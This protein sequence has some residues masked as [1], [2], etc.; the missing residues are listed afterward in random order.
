MP[1]TVRI[2]IDIGGTF[3]DLVLLDEDTGEVHTHKLLSRPDDVSEGVMAGLQ[4]LVSDPRRVSFLV[5]GTTVG[6]NT[7]L[8]RRGGPVALLVTEGFRDVYG[9]ARANRQRMYD[10]F[11]KRP[12]PLI[13]RRH[14]YEVPERVLADGTIDSPLDVEA[15][16]GLAHVLSEREYESVAVVF[17]H[18]YM[19]PHHELEAQRTLANMLPNVPLL[20]SHRVAG[21]YREYERT[22]STVLAAYVAPVIERYLES[23]EIKLSRRNYPGPVYLM[24]SGGGVMTTSVARSEAIHTLMSGPV[25]GAVGCKLLSRQLGQ[26]NLIC[27][28]MGGTS[29]DVSLLVDA[30]IDVTSEAS[31]EGFPLLV[32]TVN[33]NSLGAGG[34]SIAWSEAGALRVGPLSAGADPGPAC[35]GGGGCE[36]TVTDANVVAGRI[37]PNHFLGGDMSLDVGASHRVIG[38]LAAEVGLEPEALAGGILSITNALMANAIR[39]VTVA[40][41]LD[42]RDFAIVAYG[43]AGPL[44]AA[45]LAQELGVPKVIV[46]RAPGTFSAWGMLNSDLRHDGV[47]PL[48]CAFDD[49]RAD[50]LEDRYQVMERTGRAAL[51]DQGKGPGAAVR[52]ERSADLRYVGQEYFVN[53]P[54][55]RPLEDT[56][57]VQLKRRFHAAYEARYGHCNPHASIEFVNL[58]LVGLG[59]IGPER[60]T[61]EPATASVPEA[62]ESTI[63]GFFEGRW[64]DT[65]VFLRHGLGL[66]ALMQ[67][68]CIV[69]EEF[70]ATV[71]PPGSTCSVDELRNLVIAC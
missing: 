41:G 52:L 26:S 53:V 71:V 8:Q 61:R 48:I 34:G 43:G 25:G 46:P 15:I 36:P 17:L 62:P 55:V 9:I 45:F 20:L 63:S 16:E 11:Y 40:R 33:V 2:G 70:S 64:F 18:S 10:L 6:L 22:S 27:I 50:L 47:Q 66:T 37:V 31:L 21:E 59:S 54:V 12:E 29:F 38:R 60:P 44:H 67:G 14:V 19:N 4:E 58:R 35:Y 30:D 51:E 69:Q 39:T 68:P 56:G 23:L 28:D 3:T 32:P 1:G 5:H 13:S 65:P 24:R 42:P 7:L 49:A 57:L